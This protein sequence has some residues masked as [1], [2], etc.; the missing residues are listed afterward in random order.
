MLGAFVVANIVNFWAIK[1]YGA[2]MKEM[3]TSFFYVL[4]FALFLYALSVIV[5]IVIYGIRNLFR[6]RKEVKTNNS[7]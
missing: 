6:N 7:L 4:T 1:S 3:F 2:P 5:R